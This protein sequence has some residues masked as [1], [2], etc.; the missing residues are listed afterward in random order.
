MLTHGVEPNAFT[1][2]SV[3]KSCPLEP[4]KSLHSQAIKFGF[5]SDLYVRTGLVDIYAR[6]GDVAS[7]QQLFDTMPEKS[8]VS[9]TAMITCYSKHGEIDRARLLFDGMMERD[10]VC[11]NVMI[12][13]YTQHGRPNEALELFRQMLSAKVKPNEVTVLSLLSACGQ[14]G[15]LESGRWLHS[16]IDNNGIQL[17]VHVGTALVD[18]YSKCGSLDDAR[19][20]F[21]KI[22]NKDVVAW[23]AMIAG[24]SMHGFSQD[25]LQL[26]TEM[27]R[28]RIHPTDITFISILSACAHAGLVS[29]GRFFFQF[30]EI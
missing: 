17:N 30:D 29:K 9:L 6:G 25:A 13:G 8:L 1:F 18:M 15:A 26:F 22:N 23:N 19:L 3:L 10:N 28:L 11:W 14:L 21:D 5:D 2:S 16:Y 7:A 4:G 27:C 12:D 20:V 24:Y